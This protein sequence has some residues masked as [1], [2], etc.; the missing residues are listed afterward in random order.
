MDQVFEPRS[1]V[2]LEHPYIVHNIERCIHSLG[3]PS[4][5]ANVRREASSWKLLI[6]PLDC[7]PSKRWRPGGTVQSSG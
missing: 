6:R 2:G 4:Q 1:L 5:I 3:G 7:E